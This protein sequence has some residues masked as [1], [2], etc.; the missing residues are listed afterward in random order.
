MFAMSTAW[1]SWA[2]AVLAPRPVPADVTD[3]SW[4]R[5]AL[6]C[7]AAW[8]S[9]SVAGEYCVSSWPVAYST[10]WRTPSRSVVN[11]CKRRRLSPIWKTET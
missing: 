6:A 10:A 11:C 5:S 7:P 9:R 2:A 1:P 3:S 8:A 4:S